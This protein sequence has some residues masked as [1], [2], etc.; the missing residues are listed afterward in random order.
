MNTFSIQHRAV[1]IGNDGKPVLLSKL[2]ESF[3]EL[4]D[5]DALTANFPSLTDDQLAGAIRFLVEIAKNPLITMSL[6]EASIP[7]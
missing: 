3:A 7:K 6:E 2:A 5:P 4:V 1:L